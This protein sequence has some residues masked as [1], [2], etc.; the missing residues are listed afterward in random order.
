PRSRCSS[1]AAAR[2][3][4]PTTRSTRC[5]PP[6]DAPRGPVT[7]P[8]TPG[9]LERIGVVEGFY[10]APWSFEERLD[11]F[12]WA[13]G[14]GLEEYL[15]A[16]KDDPFHRA[17]WQ[18][19]YPEDELARLTELVAGA[20]DAGIRFTYA[21]HPGLTMRFADDADHAALAAKARQL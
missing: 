4:C 20:A 3:P 19:P 8:A 18:D 1:T 12:R 6:T 7:D 13:A 16:P 2:G 11:F 17:R 5:D 10:G 15:Y 14:A 21:I 9:R